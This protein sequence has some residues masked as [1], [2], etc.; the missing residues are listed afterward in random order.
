MLYQL[1]KKYVRFAVKLFFHSIEVDKKA[2]L[3][4]KGP[5]LIASNHPNSFLDAIIFDILFDLPI[6]SLAR[7]DAFKNKNIFKL[8]RHLKML[9]V[10]RIREG[11]AHLNTNYETFDACIDIFK[12]GEGVLIFSEGL[13][14]NEWHL[15]SLKKGTARIAFKAWDA[16]IPL[17]VLPAGINYSSFRKGGKKI[18]IHF[19]DFIERTHFENNLP[20]GEKYTRFNQMLNRKLEPLVYEIEATDRLLLQKTFR[21]TTPLQN[22]ILLPFAILGAVVHA[23]LYLPIKAVVGWVNRNNVHF[24]SISF[25][26]LLLSYPIY[27]ALATFI[28]YSLL[29]NLLAYLILPIVPF[30]AYCYAKYNV[31]TG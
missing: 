12:K 4:S 16:D 25:G 10:Y 2:L 3:N 17:K 5:L 11:A 21:E 8:L 7:G 1:L 9:P 29:H 24:D 19:G 13:C 20:D 6:T 28:T 30:L 14:V 31:R 22:I 26:V 18:N 27:L 23:P 15:R